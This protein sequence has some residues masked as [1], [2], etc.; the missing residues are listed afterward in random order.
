MAGA[1]V[2]LFFGDHVGGE[3][4]ILTYLAIQHNQTIQHLYSME[5]APYINLSDL[6][7]GSV[8]GQKIFKNHVIL[9]NP[10]VLT[11]DIIAL[12]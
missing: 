1:G 9:M 12:Y 11:E 10:Q 8:Q 5:S 7:Q 6:Y 3:G 4:R 2:L